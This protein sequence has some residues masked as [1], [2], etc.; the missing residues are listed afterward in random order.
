MIF[1]YFI[2]LIFFTTSI[3]RDGCVGF[4][5]F[6]F[7]LVPFKTTHVPRIFYFDKQIIIEMIN[8]I[9]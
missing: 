7:G 2:T 1:F 3:I 6:C 8:S 4:Y 9:Y 5:L